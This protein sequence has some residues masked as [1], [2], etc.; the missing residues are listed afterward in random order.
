MNKFLFAF[1]TSALVMSGCKNNVVEISGSLVNPIA[2]RY[3]YLDELS[4]SQIKRV[5]STL[6]GSD[7][8]FSFKQEVTTPTF[9]ILNLDNN[10]SLIMLLEPGD[11]MRMEAFFD[12]L[13]YPSLLT[14]SKST[15]LIV[16]YN[17]QLKNTIKKLGSLN[18]IYRDNIDNPDLH[19]VMESLDSLSQVYMNEINSYTKNYIDQ[20]LTSLVSFVALYQQVA[21]NVY[22]LNPTQD[23]RYFLKV[24]SALTK[25][26]PNNELVKSLHEQITEMAMIIESRTMDNEA[27]SN[28][29]VPDIVLPTPQGDMV[30]LSSTRGSVVLLD[31]WASWCA[32]CR[33]ESPN[34][35][36]AYDAYHEK[37]FQIYQVSLDMT[38]EAWMQG[39]KD[40]KLEKWI[41]VSDLKYWNSSVVEQYRI[42]SIP[43]NYLLDINGRV[44]AA[45]LRGEALERKLAE[46]LK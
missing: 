33:M 38:K 18:G 5:D 16:E 30:S 40:D 6:I 17:N 23:L 13:S 37:G 11:N 34:L 10:N 4:P 39:I 7:G 41:H 22:V 28:M 21:P 35:V 46:I 26:Y 31:F 36:K 42:E 14:G 27:L 44:I 15:E 32:P 24:D 20:N 2:G 25:N 45:N 12:S 19:I 8:K 43:A 1:I 3:I 29:E 9:F